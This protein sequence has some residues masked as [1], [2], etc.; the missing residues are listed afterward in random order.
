M[1][2]MVDQMVDQNATYLTRC[3]GIQVLGWVAQT[4][5]KRCTVETS[6]SSVAVLVVWLC[7]NY[8]LRILKLSKNYQHSDTKRYLLYAFFVFKLK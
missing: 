5:G 1:V 4:K 3:R 2:S 8:L 6:Y 7:F